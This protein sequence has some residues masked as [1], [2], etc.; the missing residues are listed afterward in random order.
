MAAR[1]VGGVPAARAPTLF[2]RA[3]NMLSLG[4]GLVVL[5]TALVATRRKHR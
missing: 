2:A 5:L 4:W 3:G 1:A